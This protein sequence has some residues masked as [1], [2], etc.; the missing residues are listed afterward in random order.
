MFTICYY[1]SSN[2]LDLYWINIFLIQMVK[3]TKISNNIKWNIDIT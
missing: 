3:N 2:K 1:H